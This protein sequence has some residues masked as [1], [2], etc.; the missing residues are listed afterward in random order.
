MQKL[1]LAGRPTCKESG[2]GP[3]EASSRTSRAGGTAQLLEPG[4]SAAVPRR[5]ADSTP[6]IWDPVGRLAGA[7]AWMIVLAVSLCVIRSA[8]ADAPLPKNAA[9]VHRQGD[10]TLNAL[11]E[12][13]LAAAAKKKQPVVVIF[14]ADWCLP[15]KALRRLLAL[16]AAVKKAAAPGRFLFI[17]V[18]EWRG[19]AQALIAG[20]DAA[21]LPTVARVDERGAL[22]LK[23]FG[24]DLGLLSGAATA[25][26]LTRLL[27]GLA[28]VRP[29][30][31]QDAG[32]TRTLAL[33]D[34][35]RDRAEAAARPEL[36]VTVTKKTTT[37]PGRAAYTVTLTL[38]NP[39]ASRRWFVVPKDMAAPLTERPTPTLYR[40]LKFTE[41]VRATMVVFEGA[42]A[43]WAVPVGG[44]GSVEL[45]ALVID[46]PAVGATLEV[47]S[48]SGLTLGTS[49]LAFGHKLPIS[50]KISNATKTTILSGVAG[51]IVTLL[52]PKK[53]VAPVR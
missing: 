30:Y 27:A 20:A 21:Q 33:E 1:S 32:L 48:L 44:F 6:T 28:P 14:T 23:C 4:K 16:D 46:G 25:K 49:P 29:D 9:W 15:C 39:D 50:L 5:F 31:E 24:T 40:E 11:F 13:E 18:D 26:N 53:L 35:Q 38:S 47:W 7:A 43:F 41:H 45:G 19:P 8:H 34:N 12:G 17:D 3:S 2:N 37:S 42:P 52:G 10:A 22:V 36:S 51:P